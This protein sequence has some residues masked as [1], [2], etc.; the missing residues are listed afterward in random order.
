MRDQ[1]KICPLR[2]SCSIRFPNL[3]PPFLESSLG[4]LHKSSPKRVTS[5]SFSANISKNFIDPT[6]PRPYINGFCFKCCWRSRVETHEAS[7][8]VRPQIVPVVQVQEVQRHGPGMRG[9]TGVGRCV[10][11]EET[12]FKASNAALCPVMDQSELWDTIVPVSL[13]PEC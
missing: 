6:L 12:K 10:Q 4:H 8:G 5:S 7:H 13:C 3:P 2:T 11:R 1:T 9:N